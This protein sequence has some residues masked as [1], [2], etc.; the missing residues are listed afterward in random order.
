MTLLLAALAIGTSAIAGY[1]YGRYGSLF[2]WWGSI[3]GAIAIGGFVVGGI[4]LG[5][6]ALAATGSHTLA[7][8][9]ALAAWIG[10]FLTTCSVA[11]YGVKRRIDRKDPR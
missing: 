9:T 2:A 10:G 11:E 5:N 3:I 6:E 4:L 1:I 7:A 8:I